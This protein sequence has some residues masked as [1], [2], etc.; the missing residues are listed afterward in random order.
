MR[1]GS[2]MLCHQGAP[3]ELGGT[4]AGS[5]VAVECAGSVVL[6][7]R[8]VIRW[9]RSGVC[10]ME[11]D[12]VLSVGAGMLGFVRVTAGL[13]RLISVQDLLAGAHPRLGDPA[14]GHHA[15]APP[16]PGEFEA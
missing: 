16:L 6:T 14:I 4:K 1:D 2:T 10:A 12:A 11:L 15:L 5:G 9:R 13:L 3:P 7:Q 8:E